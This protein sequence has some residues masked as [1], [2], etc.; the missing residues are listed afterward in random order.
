MKSVEL[1]S[2]LLD[3]SR[4]V[5]ELPPRGPINW[6]YKP[7]KNYEIKTAIFTDQ[8]RRQMSGIELLNVLQHKLTPEEIDYVANVCGE[9]AALSQALL[10]V[11]TTLRL[12]FSDF[13]IGYG[14]YDHDKRLIYISVSNNLNPLI[15]RRREAILLGNKGVERFLMREMKLWGTIGH[16]CYHQDLAFRHRE[17]DKLSAHVAS[18][19]ERFNYE[20]DYWQDL[21][22]Y[23]ANLFSYGLIRKKAQLSGDPERIKLAEKA[24]AQAIAKRSMAKFLGLH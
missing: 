6:D 16:E 5:S 3:L 8:I 22:E 13:E 21:G 10:E 7:D 1:V 4:M 19:V 24:V 2:S 15:S 9:T 23:A 17:I 14:S 11:D 12:K 18:L 20:G